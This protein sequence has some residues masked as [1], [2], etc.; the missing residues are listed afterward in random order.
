MSVVVFYGMMRA[1]Y[2]IIIFIFESFWSTRSDIEND[3]E[4]I[5]I[6]DMRICVTLLAGR[7][8]GSKMMKK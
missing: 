3:A 4:R 8:E 6:Q 7:K 5:P 1:C 2:H